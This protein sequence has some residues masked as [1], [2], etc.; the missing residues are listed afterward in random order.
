[1]VARAA[2]VTVSDTRLSMEAGDRVARISFRDDHTIAGP[3]I[4]PGDTA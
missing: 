1:M 3:F 2:D 4:L